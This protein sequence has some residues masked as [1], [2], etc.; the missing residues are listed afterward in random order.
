MPIKACYSAADFR[1]DAKRALPSP[2]FDY[3]DG[4]ADDE[5]T[6]RHNTAAFEKYRLLPRY[7]RDI[8]AI[9]MKTSVLGAQ[10]AAPVI[11]SP[12]GMSRLFHHEKEIAVARAAADA[13]LYYSL[14]TL[15]TT[16]LEEVAAVAPGPKMFQIYIHKDRGLTRELVARCRAAGY[17]ALC[18]TVDAAVAGN[19]ERD[20]RSGFGMPPRL[21]LASL[22]SFALHPGWTLNYLR[23]P[24]FALA[25]L[26]GGGAITRGPT[27]V[28][29]YID[30]QFDRTVGWDAAARI[31]ADWG[32]PFAIK[33][34]QCPEDAR[35]AVEIGASAI[36]ISNHGGRQL[37]GA[38]APIDCVA[39]MRDAIGSAA[40]LI[41]DGGVRRGAHVLK[42]LALGANAVSFGRPYLY[43]LAAGGEAGVRR[44]LSLFL[45]EIE[46]GLGLSGRRAV[47]DLDSGCIMKDC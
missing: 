33:G 32:G 5:W 36:M 29:E 24:R 4:G 13:G 18:L 47:A 20:R 2:V 3:L 8:S 21:R 17:N 10:I 6:L 30:S 34:L 42:A 26:E 46:R 22:A 16:S 40:E 9:D 43:A 41:V 12:T 35:R 25:N 15:S 27:G 1:R 14:S 44:F 11:L 38:P 28:M 45:A 37:D 31:I 7:L 19:R 39:P 23:D